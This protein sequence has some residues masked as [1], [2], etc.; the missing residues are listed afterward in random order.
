[1]SRAQLPQRTEPP[2]IPRQ[3]WQEVE[4]VSQGAGLAWQ[5]SHACRPFA[6]TASL[7]DL[8]KPLICIM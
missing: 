3:W 8:I 1:M 4:S 6:R 7:A 2:A 5:I